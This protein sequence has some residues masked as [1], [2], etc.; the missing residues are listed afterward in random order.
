MFRKPIWKITFRFLPYNRRN[1]QNDLDFFFYKT[2]AVS[3]SIGTEYNEN[4]VFL[5]KL[6]PEKH[7][8]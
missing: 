6:C 2:I 4:H 1:T 7:M 5:K 8:K 3:S